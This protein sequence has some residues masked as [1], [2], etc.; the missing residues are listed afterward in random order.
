[1]LSNT[2][3]RIRNIFILIIVA[4]FFF[5]CFVGPGRYY[6]NNTVFEINS[7]DDFMYALD[8]GFEG[9]INMPRKFLGVMDQAPTIKEYKLNVDIDFG[10]IEYKNKI[11]QK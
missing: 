10:G 5:F 9:K 4:T 2:K 8:R 7:L 11:S 6:G 3:K 1:M